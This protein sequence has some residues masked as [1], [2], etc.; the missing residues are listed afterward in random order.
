[1]THF[2]IENF[3]KA[4][5]HVSIFFLNSCIYLDNYG[6]LSVCVF[7]PN[8]SNI[9]R[10][11]ANSSTRPQNMYPPPTNQLQPKKRG[12][13]GRINIVRIFD[14]VNFQFYE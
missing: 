13:F 9:A 7:D 12:K 5:V 8:Y 11:G 14:A 4:T 3:P 1:M 6:C 2:T 10:L